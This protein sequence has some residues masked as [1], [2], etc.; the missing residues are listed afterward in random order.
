MKDPSAFCL[1]NNQIPENIYNRVKCEFLLLKMTRSVIYMRAD[2]N[3]TH[4][5]E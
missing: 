1:E 5:H 4:H 2:A 3:E